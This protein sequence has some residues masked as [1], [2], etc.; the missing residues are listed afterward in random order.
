MC[1][2]DAEFGVLSSQRLFRGEGGTDSSQT[3]DDRSA[4]PLMCTYLPIG[5]L[6]HRGDLCL[7]SPSHYHFHH[8]RRSSFQHLR[9]CSVQ[10]SAR[11]DKVRTRY[12]AFPRSPVCKEN[13][14]FI[15]G[16]NLRASSILIHSAIALP[17]EDYTVYL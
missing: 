1:H 2:T 7:K 17:K 14:G 3:D 9:V 16:K 10:R 5:E 4:L 6:C 8:L 11:G 12:L 15:F 13:G